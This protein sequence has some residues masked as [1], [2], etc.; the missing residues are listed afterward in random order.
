MIKKDLEKT[1]A[2]IE[3]KLQHP[4][5]KIKKY[6]D[7]KNQD[8]RQIISDFN[9][10]INLLHELNQ[11]RDKSWLKSSEK[12]FTES[13]YYFW[14]SQYLVNIYVKALGRNRLIDTFLNDP[15]Q[16]KEG[17]LADFR[18]KNAQIETG[19]KFIYASNRAKTISTCKELM[20]KYPISY[21]ASAISIIK[22]LKYRIISLFYP[23]QFLF[24]KFLVRRVWF[25]KKSDL[26][27]KEQLDDLE[28]YL[29]AGDILLH[30]TNYLLSNAFIPSFWTHAMIYDGKG[31]MIESTAY[32]VKKR[33]WK[34]AA[35]A[36]YLCVLRPNCNSS[37]K[38][39]AVEF[40]NAQIGKPYDFNFDFLSDKGFVCSELV[41]KAY[42]FLNPKLTEIMGRKTFPPMDFIQ[43]YDEGKL[44]FVYFL[45]AKQFQN[46]VVLGTPKEL[47]N[48]YLRS[49]WDLLQK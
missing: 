41:V 3:K 49:Q 47:S 30:R 17:V 4:R 21:K 35:I 48:S 37:T 32:K 16:G 36:D 15:L 11:K 45:D 40:A 7:L 14:L 43:L 19:I 27:T 18:E 20:E 23:I 22:L 31:S 9:L 12:E 34:K 28:P 29:E 24:E 13:F 42:P 10:V 39:K 26:I 6:F 33:P 44:D 5:Y 46:K 25:W 2:T 8:K 38:K 1:L